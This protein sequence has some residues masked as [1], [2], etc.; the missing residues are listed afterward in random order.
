[1]C[2]IAD[3]SLLIDNAVSVLMS[4]CK[5]KSRYGGA[6]RTIS[7]TLVASLFVLVAVGCSNK[8]SGSIDVTTKEHGDYSITPGQCISGE[9]EDFFG[10]DLR[11]DKGDKIIRV[12]KDPNDG[13]SVRINI[14]GTKKAVVVNDDVCSTFKVRVKK[15]N[16]TINDIKNI[17]GRIKLDCK[18]GG[19]TVKANVKFENCH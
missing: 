8:I 19:S 11:E 9:R 12:I 4:A 10:V 18:V 14:P 7:L 2:T 16:S 1:L 15:Q 13:Y 5:C 6:M 3:A 17:K